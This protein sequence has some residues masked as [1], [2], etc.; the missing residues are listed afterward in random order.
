MAK[1]DVPVRVNRELYNRFNRVLK[2]TDPVGK[3]KLK[4]KAIV[5]EKIA[6]WCDAHE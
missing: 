3:K 4:K 1:D 5:E 2:K 6:E